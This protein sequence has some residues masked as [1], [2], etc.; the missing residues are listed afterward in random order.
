M[1]S[2]WPRPSAAEYSWP[3][4]SS[5]AREAPCVMELP[6]PTWVRRQLSNS[7]GNADRKY[8]RARAWT[9]RSTPGG[10]SISTIV[11]LGNGTSYKGISAVC[12]LAELVRAG[13]DL[14]AAA[15]VA[16][17]AVV[18]LG[19][20]PPLPKVAGGARPGSVPDLQG[21]LDAPTQVLA[22]QAPGRDID[23]GLLLLLGCTS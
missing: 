4:N 1:L 7:C 10:P 12:P 16:A 17:L 3:W 2:D 8:S 21:V 19:F 22:C 11:P 23:A 6:K 14:A 9:C 15:L 5:T 13:R 18:R 20:V